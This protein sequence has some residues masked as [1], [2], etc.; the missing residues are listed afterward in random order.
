MQNKNAFAFVEPGPLRDDDLELRLI[1]THLANPRMGHSPSYTFEMC[2][3]VAGQRAGRISVRIGCS[4]LLVLYAGQI[5]Y[6]VEEAFRG[7]RFAARS[8]R[9]VLPLLKTHG[10][11]PLWITCNPDN[12]PSR[13]TCEI[14]GAE[15]VE[16]VDLPTDTEMYR[17]GERRKCR[18]RL[19]L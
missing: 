17:Y 7:R 5:G 9:L 11:N 6:G 10:I 8:C 3:V 18:Y 19:E 2:D 12:M 15:L 13:R 14:L 1:G 16:I 4:D